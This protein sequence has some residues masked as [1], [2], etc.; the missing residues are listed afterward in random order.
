MITG[1]QRAYLR[2]M[3]HQLEPIF[4]IGKEGVT[5][6][7]IDGLNKALTKREILKVHILETAMLDTRDTCNY[8]AE[9]LGAEPVQA[10][11]N[12]FIIYRKYGLDRVI[13]ITDGNPPHKSANVTAKQRFE[14]THIA[15]ADNSAFEED[16]FEINRSEKSY[17]V[18]TLGYLKEKYPNNDL[19]FI[20]GE[21]SLNDFDKWY[22]PDKILEMCS[23]LVFP[24]KS[25]KSLTETIKVVKEKM[26][27]RIFPISA[28]VFR[29]SSTDI[30]NRVKNGQTVR[31]MLPENVR[32]YIN[33]YHLYKENEND[34]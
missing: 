11:G 15:I 23:L 27:G 10:I 17:T 9:R 5:D 34:R 1:K 7:F 26:N 20:I 16:D 6:A 12:K 25:L 29:I 4:Q 31:Y 21:D 2:K 14:M 8:V 30:R 22:K 18:N 19:F 32:D 33:K 28:P 24:R 13:F 3:A